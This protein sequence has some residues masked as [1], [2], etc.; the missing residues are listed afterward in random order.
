MKH[1]AVFG[2]PVAHSRSPEIH[3]AFGKQ[4]GI[5]LDYRKIEAPRDGFEAS[6][7]NFLDSGGLGFNVT[8][9]F[10]REAFDL[11]DDVDDG[12]RLSEA[13]NTVLVRKGRLYGAN[14]DGTG[15]VRDIK[16]NLGWDIGGLKVLLIGAGGAAAGGSQVGRIRGPM[17]TS[18]GVARPAPQRY[19]EDPCQHHPNT[20]TQ[21][22]TS[23]P[24]AWRPR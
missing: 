12:A 5:E 13:V 10:K 4:A 20:T 14:T 22:S 19:C 2:N 7:R 9:P 17:R 6:A 8:V 11:V 16:M 24:W 23:R 3:A 21:T 15:L 18:E 1:L